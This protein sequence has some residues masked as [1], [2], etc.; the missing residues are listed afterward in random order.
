MHTFHATINLTPHDIN[1]LGPNGAIRIPPSGTVARCQTSTTAAG[2][3]DGIPLVHTSYG[4]VSGV[5]ET[6]DGTLY[7]VSAMIRAALPGRHDLASPGEPVRDAAG[8]VIG[9]RHLIL[10]P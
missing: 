7:I 4:A 2:E 6:E 5:P 9:C 10:N 3:Y 1:I 8:A